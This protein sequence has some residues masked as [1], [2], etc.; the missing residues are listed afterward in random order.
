[1]TS[2]LIHSTS[3][4]QDDALEENAWA[5]LTEGQ[6]TIGV[7]D[8]WKAYSADEVIDGTDMLLHSGLFDTHCHGAG[9]FAAN[10]GLE[11]IR[12]ILD[13]NEKNQ[14]TRSLISLVSADFA[15]MMRIAIAAQ[16]LV[17]DPRFLGLHFEGPF[18][19]LDQKGAQDPSAF[20]KP[21][22]QELKQ[23]VEVGTV[24]SI[25]VAPE[26]FSVNQL[27]TLADGGIK[28]AFGHSSSNYLEALK[29]FTEHEYS[30][31]THTFNGMKGIHHREP[32]PVPAAIETKTFLELIADGVHV[33]P[34]AARLIPPERLILVTDAIE[35]TGQ[36]DGN[37]SLGAINVTVSDG[38]AKTRSGSLAGSTLMLKDAVKNFASWTS[39][40]LAAIRA[41]TTNP[42][43]AYGVQPNKLSL[44]SAFLL[45][46]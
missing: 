29:F 32:G 44:E 38:V 16:V 15:D 5:V 36:P 40:P 2:K 22:N 39:S 18:L 43:H 26:V 31:M 28:L 19:S 42:E 37:Y 4:F 46:L 13:F 24:A 30:V 45:S 7:G 14:V 10:R 34:S 11:D 33:S 17:D 6:T 21:T 1:L 12:G 41:A 9:G 8:R 25:T 20:K 35:A 27:N 3:I 23:I